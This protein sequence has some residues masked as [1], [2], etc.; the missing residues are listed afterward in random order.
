MLT[1]PGL[2]SS[3]TIRWITR[4]LR[5]WPLNDLTRHQDIHLSVI[6]SMSRSRLFKAQAVEVQVKTHFQ[7]VE[8]NAWIDLKKLLLLS[9][10]VSSLVSSIRRCQSAGKRRKFGRDIDL[11]RGGARIR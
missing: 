3:L 1:D 10:S 9:P 11:R 6:F 2:E 7:L 4:G 8:R 5:G